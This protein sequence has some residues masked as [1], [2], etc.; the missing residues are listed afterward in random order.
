MNVGRAIELSSCFRS[1]CALLGEMLDSFD[2][3]LTNISSRPKF[4][5]VYVGHSTKMIIQRADH[6]RLLYDELVPTNS[7]ILPPNSGKHLVPTDGVMP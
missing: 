1:C 3:G 7:C 2:Q 5:H 4:N 6:S